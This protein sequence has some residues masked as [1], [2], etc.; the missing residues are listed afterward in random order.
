M[1]TAEILQRLDEIRGQLAELS[2]RVAR[3][4]QGS[5][6]PPAGEGIPDETV[7]VIAAAVAA[8]LG[9]RA[10]IRQIRLVPSRAWA[11]EGRVTIQASH[12]LHT[13]G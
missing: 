6:K 11:Q 7:S 9:K 2:E 12:R 1:K 8:F 4:E 10:S 13:R 3:L 5:Q